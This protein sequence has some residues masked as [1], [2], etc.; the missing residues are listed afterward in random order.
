MSA[1]YICVMS[2]TM[3][4][5]HGHEKT[6]NL[7]DLISK[8]DRKVAGGAVAVALA[9]LD[10]FAELNEARGRDAGDKVLQVWIETLTKSLP[11][12]AIVGRLGGDE[13]GIALPN[14]S[15]ENALILLD[16]V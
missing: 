12:D 4:D 13:F 14:A 1:R 2:I 9:D 3:M 16:E 8:V 6:I 15:A 11:K 7:D 5:W 10:R